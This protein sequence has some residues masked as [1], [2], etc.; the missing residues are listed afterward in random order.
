MVQHFKRKLV[1]VLATMAA[2]F[3][4]WFLGI[5]LFGLY[6]QSMN[7]YANILAHP[8]KPTVVQPVVNPQPAVPAA[9]VTVGSASSPKAAVPKVVKPAPKSGDDLGTQIID[10]V[11][12]D[13]ADSLIKKLF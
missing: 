4:L 3:V 12:P 9:P 13:A 1:T 10:K 5:Y 6:L 7:P 8:S 2:G 11:V